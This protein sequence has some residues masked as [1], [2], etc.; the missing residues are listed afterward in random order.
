MICKVKIRN[1]KHKLV[2]KMHE[3]LYK[4]LLILSFFVIRN[5]ATAKYCTTEKNHN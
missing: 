3:V 5:P 2:K 1:K 4:I